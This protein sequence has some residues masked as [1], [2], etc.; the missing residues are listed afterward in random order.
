MQNFPAINLSCFTTA[1]NETQGVLEKFLNCEIEIVGSGN[2]L[3]KE[4][5]PNLITQ[6][7]HSAFKTESHAMKTHIGCGGG[8]SVIF[9]VSILLSLYYGR[10]SRVVITA[11]TIA[12]TRQ[13]ELEF[14]KLLS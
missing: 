13:L 9:L 5:Q 2:S 12:L 7:L 1:F 6:H 10:A 4:Y 3:R 11:P 8:K 14:I